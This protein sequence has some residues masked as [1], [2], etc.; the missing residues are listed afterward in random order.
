MLPTTTGVRITIK[1][2]HT[3]PKLS[4]HLHSLLQLI[5]YAGNQAQVMSSDNL[6]LYSKVLR[7]HQYAH[8]GT[9]II[10]LIHV[11]QHCTKLMTTLDYSLEIA[12]CKDEL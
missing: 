11:L 1:L 8:T 4:Q 9:H 2:G 6:K 7:T 5:L 12:L 3:M 10:I